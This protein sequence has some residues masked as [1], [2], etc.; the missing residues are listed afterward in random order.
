MTLKVL[1]YAFLAFALILSVALV[2]TGI[3][4]RNKD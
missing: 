3:K 2:I 4:R 1:R